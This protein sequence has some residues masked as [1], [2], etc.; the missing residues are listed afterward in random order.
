MI[1][2]VFLGTPEFAVDSLK[3]LN[4][5]ENISVELVITQKD[6][7]RNRGKFTPTPVK[8]YALENN[9]NVIT[10]ENI[11]DENILKQIEEINPDIVVVVAFGQILDD[12][13]LNLFKDRIINL[14]SS[15]L[16]KYRGAAPINWAIINGEKESGITI[17]LVEKGL[18][19]GDILKIEKTLIKSDETAEDL[20]D[21]L[22]VLG[23]K[24][25]V[26][27]VNSFKEY[28]ANRSK[29]DEDIASY[30]GML[31]KS[32]GKIDWTDNCVNIYN[33]FRGMY[34]WPGSFFNYE[35]KVVK[36]HEMNKIEEKHSFDLGYVKSVNKDGILVAVKD[37]YIILN[38]IQFPNKKAVNVEDFLRG[39]SFEKGMVLK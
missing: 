30:K 22:K 25:L 15:V 28:Y 24:A 16:P 5:D 32:M 35:D 26:E 9:L 11:N 2:V 38:K 27:V 17:M 21:R 29:Q 33:K 13:I 14:H 37:G 4:E 7:K 1:K 20:H 34:P 3:T 6:K 8:E 19:T 12:K 36:V 23:A 39:N 18:D 10:P 31:K